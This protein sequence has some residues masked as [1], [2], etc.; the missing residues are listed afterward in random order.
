[1]RIVL[2]QS[3]IGLLL[4]VFFGVLES[5]WAAKS[6]VLAA[7]CIVVPNLYYIWVMARTTHAGRLLAQGV[8]R[9]IVAMVA[10]AV[11]IIAVGIEPLS[12]FSTLAAV[13]L[14]YL[15]RAH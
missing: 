1:M 12:F 7:L 4:A 5:G 3:L 10:V 14:A 11:C 2:I 15:A 6:A 9:T 8:F 13:H